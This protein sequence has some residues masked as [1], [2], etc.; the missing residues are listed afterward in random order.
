MYFIKLLFILLICS[1]ST[2]THAR[3]P[4]YGDGTAT[5]KKIR[6]CSILVNRS[7][8]LSYQ[9]N[10]DYYGIGVQ[11]PVAGKWNLQVRKPGWFDKD[12]YIVFLQTTKERYEDYEHKAYCRWEP[13]GYFRFVIKHF[14]RGG[15]IICE[16][17]ATERERMCP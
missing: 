12:L 17:Y 6:Y 2:I 3:P 15:P 5:Q 11:R 16:S 1:L 7:G 10:D 14:D 9:I 4:A 8:H 13:S